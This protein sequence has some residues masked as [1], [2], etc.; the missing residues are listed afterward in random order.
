VRM[1]GAESLGGTVGLAY[2][3]AILR[4]QFLSMRLGGASGERFSAS[5]RWVI[6]M[7]VWF[8]LA[9]LAFKLAAAAT[10]A[11]HGQCSATWFLS[12]CLYWQVVPIFSARHGASLDHAQTAVYPARPMRNSSW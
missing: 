1:V 8:L 5:S 4:A 12:I 9:C 2:D 11:I 6:C 7:R 3:A 10:P